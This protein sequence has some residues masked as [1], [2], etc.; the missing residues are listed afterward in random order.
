MLDIY[1]GHTAARVIKETGLNQGQIKTLLGASGGPKWF[2]LYGLDKY[3]MGDFFS[4]RTTPLNVIGSSVG[5]FRAAC[6]AQTNPVASTER[7]A[8]RYI[9]TTYG[10]K[11]VTPKAVTDSVRDII[12]AMLEDDGVTSIINNPI[13]KAHFIVTRA[14]G[15]V[16]S[17]NRLRQG[18]GLLKSARINKRNRA[19]LR[20]QYERVV[21][22]P[23]DST[24]TITDP[25]A[26]PTRTVT[27][28]E[29][30][31]REAI[32]ASGSLP[33]I[34]QGIENIGGAPQG[35][36]RDGG[37]VDYHFDFDLE[38]DSDAATEPGNL[39]AS[40]TETPE[41]P[42]TF[43]AASAISA[44]STTAAGNKRDDGLILYPH[45]SAQLRAG[46]FDK[47]LNRRVNG[48]HYDRVVLICPSAEFI[49][50]LPYGKIPDRSDFNKL[51]SN[52]R[53]KFWRQTT[54]E[55]EKLAEAFA[56]FIDD[57]DWSRM[58]PISELTA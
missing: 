5:S 22:Q 19:N 36:Y 58:R 3:L 44:P 37:I 31:T 28:T 20:Q 10:S 24:V 42:E 32:L 35:R 8:Q 57:E 25:Y 4:N 18:M 54:S 56:R 9:D 14:R 50:Q 23:E 2:V 55:S 48:A 7:L 13:V 40:T 39:R 15:M 21:F 33:I 38:F 27:L 30:N 52:D 43:G 12:N 53:I 26:I 11:Y 46:W 1:A 49:S 47:K 41:L 17:E 29:S 45:F 51:D 16:A 6:F 34:M